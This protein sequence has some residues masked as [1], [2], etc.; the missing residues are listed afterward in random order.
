[1]LFALTVA[2][3]FDA[4]NGSSIIITNSKSSILCSL[5]AFVILST[6]YYFKVKLTVEIKDVM[7]F[8]KNERIIDETILSSVT[9]TYKL[10]K[11]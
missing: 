9:K 7:L 10:H 1:M 6:N 4:L 3:D 11:F 5:V 8:I 2:F